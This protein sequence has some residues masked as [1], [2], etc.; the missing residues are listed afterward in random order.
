MGEFDEPVEERDLGPDVERGGG[1]VQDE[2]LGAPPEGV[3]RAGDRDSL[4]L[5]AAEIGPALVRAGESVASPS[6]MLRRNASR[7]PGPLARTRRIAASSRGA[8]TAPIA[9]LSAAVNSYLMK[10]WKM[11]L[12]CRR[13]SA[14]SRRPIV[15]PVGEDRAA[16][17]LVQAA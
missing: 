1:L 5:A 6:G 13:H 17:R 15:D 10:S 11:T 2:D 3:E 4:P 7:M 12:T 14:T 16:G 8:W 9:M